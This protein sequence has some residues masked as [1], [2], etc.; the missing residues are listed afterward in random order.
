MA[1]IPSFPFMRGWRS[2]LLFFFSDWRAVARA[3]RPIYRHS[4]SY[5]TEVGT[6]RHSARFQERSLNEAVPGG[7]EMHRKSIAALS[8]MLALLSLRAGADPL[9]PS[10]TYRNLPSLPFD[11]VKA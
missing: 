9:P 10:A 6:G 2:V 3:T 7:L 4:R 8:A 5:F 11:T 1:S